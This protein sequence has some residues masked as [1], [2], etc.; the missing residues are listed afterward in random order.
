[1]S[2][3]EQQPSL[4]QEAKDHCNCPDCN[5]NLVYAVGWEEVLIKLWDVELRCPNCEKRSIVAMDFDTAERC[6]MA[7]DEGME[8]IQHDLRDMEYVNMEEW[9]GSFTIALETDLI[10]PDNF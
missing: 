3:F 8:E 2:E 9:I 7:F 6:D 4:P 5:S 1:M 10:G